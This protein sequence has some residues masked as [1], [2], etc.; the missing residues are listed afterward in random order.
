MH[1][2]RYITAVLREF[3]AHWV[4]YFVL[5]NMVGVLLS[6]L[7]IP[8]LRWLTRA[9][10]VT[11]G[12]PY[13]TLTNAPQVALQHPAVTVGLLAIGISVLVLIY[14][15]FAV[16][17]IGVD[18]I[19]RH[20]GH[21]WRGLWQSVWGSLRHLRWTSLFFFAPYCLIVIPAAGLIVGSSLLAKV[22]VPI[23]ITAWLL[24]RPPLAA[25][26]G[27][28]YI[29]MTYLAVRW[30]RVLPL[31]I[32]GQQHLRAAARQSWR[33]TR[34]HWWFYFVRATLLGVTVWAIAYVWS[35][36]WIGIQQLCD[37][38]AFAYPAAI[39]TM[40]LMVVGKV[41]L[42]AMGSTA[43]LLFLLEPR[44]LTRPVLPRIQ[45]H[46]RR[47]TLVTAGLVVTGALVGLV[48]FNAVYLKGAAADHPL[49][50]SHRGVDGNNG[51]QN[52]IPAMRRTAREHP[53]YIEIDV[54]ETKDDQFVV[55][56]DEN[57]R[58]SWD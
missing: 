42:G 27:L 51:V 14:L 31:A 6:L 55:L 3:W 20:D 45:P 49:T 57:L 22:R 53:D 52:T 16:L 23:F 39:V 38:Y 21:G 10:L 24:E 25:L 58:T 2:W 9:V 7:V 50:I 26:V 33:A 30:L 13:L 1:S 17:L 8:I 28:L 18:R 12:V 48:A 43:C 40:T 54:H 4:S 29:I 19:H 37:S 15:Q 44:A 11:G 46:Y 35:E 56:H 41:I 32:L 34:G 5:I 36:A 47:G